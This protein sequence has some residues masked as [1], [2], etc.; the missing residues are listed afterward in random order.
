MGSSYSS[1]KKMSAEVATTIEWGDAIGPKKL[2]LCH[3]G[4]LN[5]KVLAI[6]AKKQEGSKNDSQSNSRQ[7]EPDETLRDGSGNRKP[8][9]KG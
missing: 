9:V 3:V 8:A 1:L 6:S 7:D 4:H 2:R 5:E